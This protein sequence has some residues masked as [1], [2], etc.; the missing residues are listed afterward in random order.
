MRVAHV[1]E[2]L[3]LA[4]MPLLSLGQERSWEIGIAGGAVHNFRSPLRIQQ[5][6][7][8]PIRLM[9]D[10]RT[11]PFTPPIYYDVRL[12]SLKEEKGWEL[13]FTHHKLI[14]HNNPPEVQRLSITDGFNLL[15]INRLWQIKGLTWSAGAG[16]VITHPEST[17]RNKPFPENRGIFHKGYYISGPT[18]EAAVA[19]RYYFSERWF[20][21]CE[22][23]VTASYV[24]VPVVDGHARVTNAAVHL[25]FGAGMRLNKIKQPGTEN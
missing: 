1:F 18:V 10:Y 17:I 16:I 15:T 23:R 5:A 4:M 3:L 13:K 12:S 8:A 22:G 11:E 21:F 7:A 20:A 24:Q 9:A 19:K 14:L 25:L 6:D 2:V